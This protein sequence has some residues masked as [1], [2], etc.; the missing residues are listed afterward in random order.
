MQRR[1]A[2]VTPADYVTAAEVAALL[3]LSGAHAF[4]ARRLDLEDARGFPPP[5]PWSRCPLKWRREDVAAWVDGL[6]GVPSAALDAFPAPGDAARRAVM[7][8]HAR[9]S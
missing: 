6:A 4:L 9:K 1:P 7:M 2:S 5:V 8:Q 3:G